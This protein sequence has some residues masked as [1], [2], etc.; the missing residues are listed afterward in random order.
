MRPAGSPYVTSVNWSGTV[1]FVKFFPL[2]RLPEFLMGMACGYLFVRSERNQKFALPIV[3]LGLLG[4][5]AVAAAS[6]FVPYLV[7]HTAMSAP[8]FA[9]L[10]Y[11]IAL[12]SKWASWLNNRL[13]VLFGNASYSFYLLHSIFVWPFFHDLRTQQVRNNGFISIAIWTV[14]MLIIV[15]R[16]V[17]EPARRK[18]R[19]KRDT[20]P[21]PVAE[22][23]LANETPNL[24]VALES[25]RG[26]AK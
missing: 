20:R 21:T 15:Y 14:M 16:F 23:V 9:V 6:K 17:E 13:L 11:G 5:A 19:P 26:A 8:A 3:A 4:V 7:V 22:T 2:V 25:A 18:L 24:C 12:E 10:V 1:Q